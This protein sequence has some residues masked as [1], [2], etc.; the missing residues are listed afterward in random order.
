[1]RKSYL[2]VLILLYVPVIRNI[3]PLTISEKM[4]S[5]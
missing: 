1:M 4:L 2:L 3:H 5:Y